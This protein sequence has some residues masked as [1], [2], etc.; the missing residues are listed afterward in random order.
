M[1]I[2]IKI[3]DNMYDQN[4]DKIVK[5]IQNG[6]DGGLNN[7]ILTLHGITA[8]IIEGIKAIMQIKLNPPNEQ[9]KDNPPDMIPRNINMNDRIIFLIVG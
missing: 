1:Y 3:D 2:Q 4:N 7:M 5:L 9:V 6:I 8:K